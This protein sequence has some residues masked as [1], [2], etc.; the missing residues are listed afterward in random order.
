M[1]FA[2]LV[3]MAV[4]VVHLSCAS[5]PR[6]PS[7]GG[8]FVGIVDSVLTGAGGPMTESCMYASTRRACT[9]S[10]TTVILDDVARRLCAVGAANLSFSYDELERAGANPIWRDPVATMAHGPYAPT[11]RTFV[12]AGRTCAEWAASSEKATFRTCVDPTLVPGPKGPSA[13][14]ARLS[15]LPVGLPLANEIRLHDGTSL[16]TT[17]TRIELRSVEPNVPSCAPR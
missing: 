6:A 4:L 16:T 8:T 3:P 2:P 15:P 14:A 13:A 1:R 10:G 11:G 12:V 7:A 9:G 17:V 5:E